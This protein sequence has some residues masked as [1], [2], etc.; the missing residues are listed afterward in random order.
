M[1]GRAWSATRTF[2]AR[3]FRQFVPGGVHFFDT[4]TWVR[5][6]TVTL[7]AAPTEVRRMDGRDA[8]LSNNGVFRQTASLSVAA[9]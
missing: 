4:R 6:H 3:A 2:T 9:R 8:S 5:T 7:P 1:S